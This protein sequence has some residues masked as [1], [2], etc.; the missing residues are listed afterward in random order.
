MG[1]VEGHR[2]QGGVCDRAWAAGWF[3]HTSCS[4]GR[5]GGRGETA[6][7]E[8]RGEVGDAGARTTGKQGSGPRR[9]QV[10]GLCD[11]TDF[12]LAPS[13]GWAPSYSS[14]KNQDISSCFWKTSSS[15]PQSKNTI[16]ANPEEQGACSFC[17]L[18]S[19]DGQV[20]GWPRLTAIQQAIS[21]GR[22]QFL[23][24]LLLCP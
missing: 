4:T 17:D 1:H 11:H 2:S 23:S 8:G 9:A 6:G 20:Q 21:G 14:A 24:R 15:I 5:F 12:S 18:S 19:Q 7:G 10:W 13:P 16:E 3:Y 22:R